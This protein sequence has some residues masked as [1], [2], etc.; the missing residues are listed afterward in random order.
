MVDTDAKDAWEDPGKRDK[1]FTEGISGIFAQNEDET[2]VG[3]HIT[4]DDVSSVSD[5]PTAVVLSPAEGATGVS[6]QATL[7]WVEAKFATSRQLWFGTP[8]NLQLVD[9]APTGT[10]YTTGMLL[11][12]QTYQWRVDEVGAAGTV[13]GHVWQFTT[14]AGLAID[15]F[16]SYADSAAIAAAW[17]HNIPGYDYIFLETGTIHQGAKAMKFTYQNGA[18]PFVTEATR[19]FATAQDWTIGNPAQLS[20]DF[21]GMNDNVEQPLYVTLEDEA[22][23]KATVKHP[24]SYAVQ[25]EP[26]RT[27]DTALTDFAG[28]NLAAVKKLGIGSG[29][30][31]DSGQ[32]SGDVDTLYMDNI[33]LSS[34]APV[35]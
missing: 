23:N 27:W 1:V 11:P 10:S 30:G 15:D 7:R 32:A 9:P 18:D 24:L 2:P 19:T 8:D 28:V 31:T 13:T 22:G 20:I 16:E 6:I 14:G 17:P 26:W 21:R 4:W 12:N 5:G 3:F 25:S 34:F 29:S 35:Q 33:R